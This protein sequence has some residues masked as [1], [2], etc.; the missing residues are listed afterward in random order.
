MVFTLDTGGGS[1]LGPKVTIATA[2]RHNAMVM[3]IVPNFVA[4]RENQ[5]SSSAPNTEWVTRPPSK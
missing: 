4:V 3:L 5:L 2:N 1:L